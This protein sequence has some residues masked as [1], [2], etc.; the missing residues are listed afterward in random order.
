MDICQSEVPSSV[1]VGKPFV[2]V[3]HELQNGRLQVVHMDPVFNRRK[4]EL[5]GSAVNVAPAY[6]ATS[7]PHTK[8]VV[9]VIAT[10]DLALISTRY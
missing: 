9:V 5:V 6:A 10:I 3:A 7:H 1:S 4:P 8:A 2:V